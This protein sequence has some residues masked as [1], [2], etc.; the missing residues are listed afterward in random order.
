M[1]STSLQPRAKRHILKEPRQH[2]RAAFERSG[3]QHSIRFESAH[4]SRR[5][6]RDNHNL[7][8]DQFFRLVVL[9]NPRQNLPLLVPRS[10][11]RRNSLSAFGTRSATSICA[12]R[13]S[14][15]AKSSIVMCC[16]LCGATSG[17]AC[18]TIVAGVLAGALGIAGAVAGA[19]GAATFAATGTAG[20]VTAAGA[21]A[22]AGF[23]GAAAA[24]CFCAAI[25][26]FTS[27]A[28]LPPPAA[29]TD[30]AA[31]FVFKILHTFNRILFRAWKQ[32]RRLAKL[33]PRLQSAP[34]KILSKM[35]SSPHPPISPCP[36]CR[37]TFAAASGRIGYTSAVITRIA[38]AA[39]ASTRACNF[40]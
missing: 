33:R 23:T 36:S 27:S 7:A 2:R 1:R 28:A 17:A 16:G 39:V 9:R 25:G 22:T 30:A 3:Q 40:A 32:R 24:S 18:G 13:S 11:S 12:T 5:Q 20:L 4:L 15:L 21:F 31:V 35:N 26:V 34:R 10:T 29:S 14:T 19:V 37:H 6:I 8:A 38:S